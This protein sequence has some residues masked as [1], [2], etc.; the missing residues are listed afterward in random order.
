MNQIIK[1]L[2]K[3]DV[4]EKHAFSCLLPYLLEEDI[5]LG[6][7]YRVLSGCRRNSYGKAKLTR[8]EARQFLFKWHRKR[9]I[10][11]VRDNIRLCLS[12]QLLLWLDKEQIKQVLGF[13]NNPVNL[14]SRALH[15]Q[16][17]AQT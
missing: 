5:G 12:Q 2:N 10:T 6:V 1:D 8:H 15:Q 14:R 16:V 13:T 11:I 3:N 7:A 4:V 9:F 17:E